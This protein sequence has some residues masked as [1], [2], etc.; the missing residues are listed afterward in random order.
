MRNTF[1]LLVAAVL[2]SACGGSPNP[3]GGAKDGVYHINYE[4]C[5]ANERTLRLSEIADTIEYLE[6]KTPDDLIITYVINV[7]PVEDFILVHCRDGLFKFKRNGDFVT[8][9]GFCHPCWSGRA[10]TGRTYQDLRCRCGSGAE[11]DHPY[12]Y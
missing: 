5:L 1:V 7:I 6:L 8:R 11:R 9:V 10:R 3:E 4:E 12:G 2:L